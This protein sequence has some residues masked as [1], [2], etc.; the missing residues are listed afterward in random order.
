MLNDYNIAIALPVFTA[1]RR[2]K[3][4]AMALGLKGRSKVKEYD[5]SDGGLI[6]PEIY[7]HYLI[8]LYHDS[9]AIQMPYESLGLLGIKSSFED[10]LSAVPSG[11][12]SNRF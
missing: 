12:W 3:L 1:M 4:L 7:S 10:L 11:L 8:G 2:Q 6:D 5:I 9:L